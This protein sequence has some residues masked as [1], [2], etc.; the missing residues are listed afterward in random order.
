LVCTTEPIMWPRK[1]VPRINSPSHLPRPA[2]FGSL[3]Q[4]PCVPLQHSSDFVRRNVASDN[5]VQ[6][7]VSL[8]A[9]S[10]LEPVRV[11]GGGE[12]NRREI[13]RSPKY[14]RIHHLWNLSPLRVF[15]LCSNIKYLRNSYGISSWNMGSNGIQSLEHRGICVLIFDKWF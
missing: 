11:G 6:I 8:R 3:R 12:H 5:R 1:E 15:N 13:G 2:T 10:W 14:H 9:S 4:S 7:C